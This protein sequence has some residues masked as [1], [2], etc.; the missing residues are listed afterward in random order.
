[1]KKLQVKKNNVAFCSRAMLVLWFASHLFVMNV[2]A[3]VKEKVAP[4]YQLLWQKPVELGLED[5]S[6]QK[7]LTFKGSI[8]SPSKGNLPVFHKKFLAPPSS[9]SVEIELLKTSYLPLTQAEKDA[10]DL[11]LLTNTI[12]ASS[13]WVNGES[14]P[15]FIVNFVPIRKN[16]STGVVEKLVSFDFKFNYSQQRS[17]RSRS[18]TY[19]SESV[20]NVGT[21]FKIGVTKDGVYKLD[22][23]FFNSQGVDITTLDPRNIRVFGTGG[24]M[25]SFSNLDD[26]VDDL[27]ELPLIVK[28]EQDGVMDSLDFAWFYAKGPNYWQKS[29]SCLGY[30]HQLHL[31]SDTSYYFVTV[32]NGAGKR[33]LSKSSVTDP[34]NKTVNSFDDF[35][36]YQNEAVNVVKSGR[37]WFGETF[38]L[39]TTYTFPFTFPDVEIGST[40]SVR[41][42]VAARRRL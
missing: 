32:D 12:D 38:D 27:Q 30:A 20:L 22:R 41:A 7:L 15:Y 39:V 4:V 18:F 19:A 25:L 10:I 2:Y 14:R 6:K 37:N 24:K 31:Y 36:F 35:Q 29:S 17:A 9:S 42:A 40:F 33:I 34:A 3:Q 28:G 1:M 21:W 16:P 8:L 23:Q 13:H 5:G 26:R 11:N